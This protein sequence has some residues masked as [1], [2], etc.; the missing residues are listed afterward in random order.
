MSPLSSTSTTT[1]IDAVIPWVDGSDPAHKSRLD[2]YLQ[3]TNQRPSG[4]ASP[5]RFH[6]A[7]ELDYCIA[8][9]L[10]F[11]PWIR[12]IYIVTDD[13]TPP[14][15]QKLKNT[16]F[17]AKIQIV[18][19]KTIFSGFEQHLPTFNSSSILSV[20]WRIPNLSE[21][22]LFLNDDFIIVRPVL[23]ENFFT[24]ETD[25]VV[26]RGKWRS[27]RDATFYKR[28]LLALRET[29][30]R[31]FFP[32]KPKRAGYVAAQELSAKLLGFY[33]KFF[34]LT[35]NPHAMRRSAQERF[36][37]AHPEIL[38][39]NVSFR[40][41]SPEQFIIEAL[42]AHIDIKE[43]AAVFSDKLQTLMLKP[44]SQS[45]R[46]LK[47]KLDA[48]DRDPDLAFVCVQSLET[49]SREAQTLLTH[50]LDTCV[51]TLPTTAD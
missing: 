17:A 19:H 33:E 43:N 20:L 23:P 9:L 35:H 27:F 6:N 36:F 21:H 30:A 47:K 24:P 16:P 40:L 8:A 50:W 37:N 51:G 38:A 4:D 26:L 11:A 45:L 10:R 25:K 39:H 5:T 48:A 31:L 2:A 42:S 46:R 7:G 28:A 14:L 29:A 1:P 12:T 3:S 15:I 32:K 44:G 49:G 18:D 34:L 41:R 22:F 13:Q